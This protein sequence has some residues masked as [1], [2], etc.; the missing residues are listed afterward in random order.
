MHTLER[1]K[2]ALDDDQITL[3][4][5]KTFVEP[6]VYKIEY[7]TPIVLR[8]AYAHEYAVGKES[9]FAMA[10]IKNNSL[11]HS[12]VANDYSTLFHAE[13]DKF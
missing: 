4:G 6:V 10:S 12:L 5:G 2:M 13:C 11:A 1:F 7:Q 8:A 9:V 3:K